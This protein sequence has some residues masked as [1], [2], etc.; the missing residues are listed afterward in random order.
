MNAGSKVVAAMFAACVGMPAAALTLTSPTCA[1]D[2]VDPNAFD[3]GGSFEGNNIGAPGI[4]LEVENYI[5][6]EWGL[7]LDG[8]QD[9]G[10]D[11]TINSPSDASLGTGFTLDLGQTFTGPFVLA[12]KQS[13]AFAL[14]YYNGSEGP[15]QSITYSG[16]PGVE[17]CTGRCE[18]GISHATVYGA[19]PAIPEPSTYALML[20]G[21]AAV[22]FMARRRRQS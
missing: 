7:T 20:A 6:A 3:C 5:S 10:D 11:F 1:L 8:L 17:D 14:Y 22:G 15:I 21:L 16:Y 19:V 9:S 18:A 2:A 4:A 13:T 12:I